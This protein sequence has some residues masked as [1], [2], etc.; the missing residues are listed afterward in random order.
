L[1]YLGSIF[2]KIIAAALVRMFTKQND[3][4][5]YLPKLISNNYFCNGNFTR[6]C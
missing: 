2:I 5:R 4:C 1:F 6:N 3:G